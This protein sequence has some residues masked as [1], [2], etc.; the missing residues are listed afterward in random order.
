VFGAAFDFGL[1]LLLRR[2]ARCERGD[3][4]KDISASTPHALM[5][6]TSNSVVLEQGLRLGDS[7]LI[8]N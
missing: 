7:V 6:V 1:R 5:S 4:P 3:R 2:A 8:H